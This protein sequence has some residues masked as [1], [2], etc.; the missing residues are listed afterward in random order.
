MN[1]IFHQVTSI[2]TKS[3]RPLLFALASAGAISTTAALLYTTFNLH[4]TQTLHLKSIINDNDNE[5]DPPP[6]II[7]NKEEGGNKKKAISEDLAGDAKGM[8]MLGNNQYGIVDPSTPTE[9]VVKDPR[10]I[11]SFDKMSFRSV[12]MA[13]KHAGIPFHSHIN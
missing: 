12:Y 10:R 9:V 2:N 6:I 3:R 11:Q 4:G 5:N 7:P 13:E 1:R 8:L